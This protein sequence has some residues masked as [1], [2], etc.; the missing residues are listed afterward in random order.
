MTR[1][2]L[3]K[4]SFTSGELDPRLLGRLDLKA[5]EDGA[6]RLRNVIVHP[7]GGVTRRPG[8]TYVAAVPGGLRMVPFDGP[9]GGEILV[10]GHLRLD[11]VKQGAIVASVTEG[12][13]WQAA[14]VPGLSWARLNDTLLVCHPRI[15]PV[16]L[17]RQSA[18]SWT[19]QAWRFDRKKLVVAYEP[20]LEPFHKFAPREV[21]ISLNLPSGTAVEDPVPAG[22]SLRLTA[23]ASVFHPLHQGLRLML[24]GRQVRIFSVASGTEVDVLVIEDLVDG[25]RTVDW[26]EPAFSD[27]RGFPTSVGFHQN[28]L[29]IGGS[30]DLPDQIWM[31]KTGE[32]FDFDLGTGLDDEALSFRLAAE[33]RH[34]VSSVFTGRQ[35]QVFTDVGEW[36]VKGFPLTPTSIQVDLQTSVGS[37]AARR[38]PPLDVDGATLFVGA[39][40]RDLREFLFADTEQAYQ[41]ADLALLSRHLMQAPADIAFDQGRRLLLVVRTDGAL[42][43]VTLD[44]NS[45]VVA[46]TLL[47][48]D[49]SFRAALGMAG[50][51]WLLVERAGSTFLERLDESVTLDA[52]RSASDDTTPRYGWTGFGHL[53]GRTVS[54]V[55]DG[56][57]IYQRTV[58]GGQLTVSQAANTVT[59]GL[60]YT[61]E[62]EA[63]PLMATT[64]RGLTPDLPYRPV[65]LTFRLLET[66]ALTVDTGGGPRA[67]ALPGTPPF[68]GDVATR[69]VGWRRGTA[70]PP[71][72]VTQSAPLPC[73]ILCVTT[74]IKVND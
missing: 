42:A 31:S 72:R 33:R 18:T 58:A 16:R 14:D 45:N 10:F 30:R 8:T 3:V 28:R 13:N 11:V 36:V 7:T 4:T 48:T 73:T 9:D 21:S 50:Q 23:S 66:S 69:A 25:A 54:V 70:T 55:A 15:P 51:T 29:V 1:A 20:S 47:T 5:Q 34:V 57:R 19:A 12:I 68:T 56:S 24:Q 65:R 63:L 46:W 41:A 32:P 40:G 38:I 39:T 71:W 2:R 59:A 22:T 61:H 53:E 74:E 27:L 64:A 6:S 26:K 67:L 44:R 35:L 43:A 60:G 62:V 37:Y 52:A 49:G 17:V